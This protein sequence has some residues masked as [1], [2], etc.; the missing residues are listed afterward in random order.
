ME[1]RRPPWI[2]WHGKGTPPIKVGQ[3]IERRYRDGEEQSL[4]VREIHISSRI[5]WKHDENENDI[6][7]YRIVCDE[8]GK[9]I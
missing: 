9:P 1:D 8:T 7:A 3:T 6:V 4:R 5:L 2:D